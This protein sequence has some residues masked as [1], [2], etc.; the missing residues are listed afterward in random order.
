MHCRILLGDDHDVVLEG[1]RRILNRPGFDIVGA[2][3]DGRAL[4]EA[5]AALKPDV[6][7]TDIS[8]PQ[9]NGIEAIRQIRRRDRWCKVVF[10]TM[11]PETNY[12]V[13]AM[14]AGGSGYVLKDTAG[15]E[16]IKAIQEAMQG[17]M[18]ITP[19]LSESVRDAL[20]TRRKTPQHAILL[21]PRQREVLQLLA[22]GR[23]PK[24]I[25]AVLQMSIRTVEFHKYSI[26]QRLGVRSVAELGAYAA[27]A[28][29]IA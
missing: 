7:V 11:H 4:I 29:M 5:T 9:L 18:Y 21:T 2:V 3:K 16:L 27:K 15:E 13:E 20:R 28:G 24:E 26:M 19:L 14:S 1:L 6:I 8:M 25:S 23:S 22:E 10:L 17:R 12:A